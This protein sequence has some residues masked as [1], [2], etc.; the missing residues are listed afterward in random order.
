MQRQE[1]TQIS[2][3][4]LLN[5]KAVA[6]FSQNFSPRTWHGFYL[7]VI[8]GSTV[9]LP[10][11]SDIVNHFG[12]HNTSSGV[13]FPMARISQLFDPL[14]QVTH[15]ALI[16]PKSVGE[17]EMAVGHFDCL[18]NQDMLL[19][20]RGYPAFWLFK[21]ILPRGAH[22]C[23]IVSS[24]RWDVIHKFA[25]S[26]KLEQLVT[27]E[28]PLASKAACKD[29]QLDILPMRL[30]L[31]RIELDTGETE[32]LVTSLLDS[33]QY[34]HALFADLYHDRWSVEEDYKVMKCRIEIGNFTGQ[35]PLS[36]YQDFHARV[37]AKK[38]TSMLSFVPQDTVEQTTGTES[39]DARSTSPR[40]SQP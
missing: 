33:E 18:S 1:K 35:S 2:S 16:G 23:A 22:F 8:D 24:K 12:V 6:H 13:P 26:G 20:D 7:K 39:G 25:H 31:I 10:D 28:I 9:K 38:L 17:R 27:L 11:F 40:P 14:N 21:L 37:F 3:F 5:N 30:R 29:R 32:V 4:C 15:H 36:V 34:P 19:L